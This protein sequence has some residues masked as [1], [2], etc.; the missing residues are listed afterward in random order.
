[1]SMLEEEPKARPRAQRKI[2]LDVAASFYDEL[3][4]LA[5]DR[6]ESIGGVVRQA[7]RNEL[8]SSRTGDGFLGS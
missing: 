3:E 5:C 2:S 4:A 8:N 6:D 7:L 1:M